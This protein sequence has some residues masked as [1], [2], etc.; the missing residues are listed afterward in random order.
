[1]CHGDD[2]KANLTWRLDYIWTHSVPD[3]ELNQALAAIHSQTLQ[4]KNTLEYY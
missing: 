4:A 3:T 1:M 2:P